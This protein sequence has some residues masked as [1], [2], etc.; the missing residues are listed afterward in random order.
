MTRIAESVASR[1]RMKFDPMN[2][3]PPVTSSVDI[4]TSASSDGKSSSSSPASGDELGLC[5]ATRCVKRIVHASCLIYAMFA[6]KGRWQ[7]N[8]ETWFVGKCF[9]HGIVDLPTPLYRV[10]DQCSQSKLDLG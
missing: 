9:V 6:R 8:S 5:G 3:H 4:L 1:C 2:P 7:R 10:R